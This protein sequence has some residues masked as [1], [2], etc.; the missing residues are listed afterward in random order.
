MLLPH[1]E[2]QEQDLLAQPLALQQM[3]INDRHFS[4]VSLTHGGNMNG[5]N[6]QQ[7][8]PGDVVLVHNNTPRINW[9]LVIIE[10]LVRGNNGLACAANIRITPLVD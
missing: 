4:P 2:V 7:I 5:T 3:W 6:G 1:E 10:D 9:R 8:K